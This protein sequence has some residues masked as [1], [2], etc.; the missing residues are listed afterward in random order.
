MVQA[1][2]R[3][4]K[5]NAVTECVFCRRIGDKVEFENA[6]A[7]GFADAFP[8]SD[9]HTLVVP[10]QHTSSLI[11]LPGHVQGAAWQL[12]TEVADH[13]KHLL[14]PD[15]F[16]LGVNIGVSAGQTVD[17]A[18]IHVIPRYQGDVGDPRG[19]VRWVLPDRAAYWS[20]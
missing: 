17:H 10:K 1:S 14:H 16:N 19:G 12:V 18:H 3:A 8:V 5:G 9:G 7:V 20:S 4:K 15:G 11:D 6:F 2:L 13:L